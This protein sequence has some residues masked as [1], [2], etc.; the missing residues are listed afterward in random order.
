MEGNLKLLLCEDDENLGLI[1]GEYLRARGYSADLYPDGA[2]GYKGFIKGKYDLCILDVM[3]PKKDGITLAKEIRAIDPKVPVIFLT[4]KTARDDIT[5]GF[6]SGADDYITK[7]FSMEE[8]V[9]R[10]GA[11]LRRVVRGPK[12]QQV[13]R[14]SNTVF[15]TRKLILTVNGESTKLT[16]REGELLTLLCSHANGL[17]ERSHALKLVWG[18]DD[19]FQARSMDVYITKLRKLLRADPGIRIVNIHGKGY[20]LLAAEATGDPEYPET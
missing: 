7:P 13:Y 17:L 19:Y 5:D 15:D 10:I 8:L 11:V 14:F 4:A 6:K 20:K 12:K 2:S 9:F 3:M 18:A 16:T 1:L